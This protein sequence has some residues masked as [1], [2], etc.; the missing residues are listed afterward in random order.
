MTKHDYNPKQLAEWARKR[1][2]ERSETAKTM[3]TA[4]HASWL[5]NEAA[6]FAATAEILE[7]V[8]DREDRDKAIENGRGFSA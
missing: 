2:K 4:R 5:N 7:Q 3:G 6:R 1:S 8:A